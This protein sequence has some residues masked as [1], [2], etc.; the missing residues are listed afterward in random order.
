VWRSILA[1]EWPPLRT[2]FERWLEPENFDAAGRQRRSL[3]SMR[4]EA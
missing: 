3:S 2:M 1:D 4:D